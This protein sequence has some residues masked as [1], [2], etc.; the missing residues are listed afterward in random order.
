MGLSYAVYVDDELPTCRLRA[1]GASSIAS[2]MSFTASAFVRARRHPSVS[3]SFVFIVYGAF[4]RST[5]ATA[6][7]RARS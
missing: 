2:S 5:R 6:F 7:A 1:A 4:A 3:A